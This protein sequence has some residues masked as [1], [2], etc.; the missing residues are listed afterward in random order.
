M[1]SERIRRA[2]AGDQQALAALLKAHYSFIVKYV[3]KMSGD[4]QLAYDV[5]Q[6]TIVKAIQKIQQF[7]HKSTFSTWL[8]QMATHTYIDYKRKQK[9]SRRIDEKAIQEWKNPQAQ[10]TRDELY[11]VQEA[12]WVL[13]DHYRIP[14]VLKHYYGYDYQEISSMTNVK[15][16]TLK[17]RVHYGLKKLRKE[18]LSHER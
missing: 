11:D 10:N 14:I 4:E 16:G 3:W 9:R 2:Q 8:I 17:S 18:L 7:K 13:D 12:L 6:D 5:T 15:A 1:D